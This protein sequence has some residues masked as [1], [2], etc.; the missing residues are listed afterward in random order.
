MRNKVRKFRSDGSWPR[1]SLLNI[2]FL[3]NNELK[4]ALKGGADPNQKVRK[5]TNIPDHKLLNKANTARKTQ[6][7][8]QFGVDPNIKDF[9]GHTPIYFSK[10]D[11]TKILLKAGADPNIQ[12]I[13]YTTP[14]HYAKTAEQTRL[15]IEAGAK[16]NVKNSNGDTPLI[17][18]RTAE[19][20]RLLI[21]AGA[22]PNIKNINGY[23][24]LHYIHSFEQAKLLLEAGAEVNIKNSF[25]IT[26]LSN[27]IFNIGNIGNENFI[28]TIEIFIQEGAKVT[29][30]VINYY[31]EYGD[32]KK[33]E[34]LLRC[35]LMK[36]INWT[37]A[38]CSFQ[39]LYRNRLMN[40]NH[41]FC[42]RKL[43]E[44]FAN[45]E[46]HCL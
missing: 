13:D 4:E 26:P 2:E 25:G 9:F 43:E 33:T 39:N 15:L 20:T 12:D 40:P 23:T 35:M 46:N 36:K 42:K 6:L 19:Q 28:K 45:F 24:A 1:C 30:D 14:L 16:L 37:N 3:T 10:P 27:M 17:L 32:K 22:D 8:I 31:L 21:E 34:N 5:V 38:I 44:D 41:P 7:L 11:Q 29:Q 18:A